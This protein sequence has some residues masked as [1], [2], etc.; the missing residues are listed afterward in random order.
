MTGHLIAISVYGSWRLH[1]RTLLDFGIRKSLLKDSS[2]LSCIESFQQHCNCGF[3]S[4]L[5][6][7]ISVTDVFS[8]TYELKKSKSYHRK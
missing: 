5:N 8:V 4:Y 1:I 2:A 7:E 6:E 3:S